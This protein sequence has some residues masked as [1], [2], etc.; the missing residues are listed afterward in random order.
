MNVKTAARVIDVLEAFAR[1]AR[2]LSLSELGRLLSIPASSCFGLI[3]T[4]ENQGYIYEINRRLGYYPTKRLLMVA[5]KIAAH[6]VLLDR[7]SPFLREL[8]DA[9][10][11]TAL[12]GKLQA[13]RVVYLDVVES[14]QS[15][16]YRASAGELRFVHANSIGKAIL[17]A[18]PEEARE[19]VLQKLEWTRLTDRTI[20]TEE[21]LKA[22]LALSR[23]RGW[24]ANWGEGAADLGAV[25]WP[26]RLN[27]EW[28]AISV[29]G[30]LQ[31]MEVRREQHAG[32][33]R[34]LCEAMDR[35]G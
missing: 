9:T 1:E 25:S 30:P 15:I 28:Y 7:V 33:V 5:E 6:D 32:M 23:S 2:P 20:V 18:M 10:G 19:N 21:A 13:G 24:Y 3:R 8:R 27:N 35:L 17:G 34:Q 26:V 11:E 14:T 22:D 31:R 12:F 29:G 16:C 4:L